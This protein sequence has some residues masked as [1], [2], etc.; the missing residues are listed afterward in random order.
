MGIRISSR[1]VV[2]DLKL[3]KKT[4][5][6]PSEVIKECNITPIPEQYLR[7]FKWMGVSYFGFAILNLLIN[8]V[9]SAIASLGPMLTAMYFANS[10]MKKG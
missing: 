5:Y 7:I 4:G 3:M 8:D 9:A 10:L 1:A 2:D 6:I